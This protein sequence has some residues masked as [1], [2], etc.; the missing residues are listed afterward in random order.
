MIAIDPSKCI[1]C[2][3]CLD[4]CPC[5]S[6]TL[7]AESAVFHPERGCIRCMHCAAACPQEAITYNGK[8]AVAFE[9]I[10][11]IPE[12]FTK[13]LENMVRT[14]RSYRLFQDKMVPLEEIEHA[15]DVASWAPSAKNQHPVKYYLIRG[16]EQ[17]DL[18][19]EIV[20]NDI[21][22]KQD[23]R[24]EL[25]RSYEEG[26]NKM[27]G[28]ATTAILAY[29]R[30]NAVNP[31]TDTAIK[32]ATAELILQSKGFGTCW[33]G[34]LMRNLNGVEKLH[35]LFPLPENNQFYGCLLVGYP[36]ETYY[37]IPERIKRPDIKFMVTDKD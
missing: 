26:N 17:V 12:G 21:R 19:T 7:E 2:G 10:P 27:F 5:R 4:K 14:R 35:E 25:L 29:A 24:L 13:D 8:E 16:R 28:T 15:L 36:A 34:Y 18:V 22:E 23:A 20:M 3:N 30:N 31:Q 6:I 11:E 1:S 9:E 37:H 33:S 32:L